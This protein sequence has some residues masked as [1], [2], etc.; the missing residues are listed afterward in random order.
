[1]KTAFIFFLVSI[2]LS[3][4]FAS[5]L[6]PKDLNSSNNELESGKT[7]TCTTI[8]SDEPFVSGPLTEASSEEIN[9]LASHYPNLGELSGKP[10]LWT[11]MLTIPG[12]PTAVGPFKYILSKETIDSS[13]S[14]IMVLE[15]QIDRPVIKVRTGNRVNEWSAQPQIF[16]FRNLPGPVY[17]DIDFVGQDPKDADLRTITAV[18][19][20]QMQCAV[21]N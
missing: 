16:S 2:S 5:D 20:V 19:R 3:T 8:G 4:A 15:S 18:I 11:L 7:I 17:I 21:K 10:L 9:A 13:T 12:Y 1:M 6:G 14:R